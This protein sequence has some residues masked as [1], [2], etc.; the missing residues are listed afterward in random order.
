MKLAVGVCVVV[1]VACLGAASS[2]SS[3]SAVAPTG[4]H[5]FVLRA[6]EP[7]PAGHTYSQMPAFA[8]KPV[9]GAT[10]Y[11]L[12]LATSRS[13]ADSTAIYDDARLQAPV[14]SVPVQVPWMTGR[15]Y[16]LWAH[17]RTWVGNRVSAWSAP[18]G[19]DTAWR[20]VPQQLAAPTGLV[21]WTPVEGA[22][23]Y[24]VWFLD[25]P[26]TSGVRFTTL[27]NVA[28]ERE[29]WTFHAGAAATVHWR[30]R[31]VR[32]VRTAALDN[33]VPI[34][35]YGPYSPV[36][37]STNPT[38]A[39]T[40]PLAGAHV[41]SDV[42]STPGAVRSNALTPG[43][44]WTGA[45]GAGGVATTSGLWR[46]YVFSDRGCVN[47][48]LTGSI[49]GGPAW[50]PR[51]VDPLALPATVDD[52]AQAAAGKALGFGAQDGALMADATPVTASES[53]TVGAAETSTT[54]GAGGASG[55]TGEST[56][57][58]RAV[59]L[60]D[61]GW[62][63]GRYWWTV[64]PVEAVTDPDSGAT[65]PSSA[66]LRYVD[67]E[68]PQDACAA[69]Q[70]W[71]FGVQSAPVTTSSTTPLASGLVAAT[72]VAS[73]ATR[74][75]GFQELP[76][77]TWR[78]APGAAS[79]EVQVSRK[80]YPWK[81]AW[82]RSTDATSAVLPLTKRSVGTWYYRVRGRNP[83]LPAAAAAMAWSKP[84]AIRITGDRFVVGR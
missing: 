58:P 33:G 82:A 38:T 39:P 52:L 70:V 54:A 13:F 40:G 61:N 60:P 79:Y 65:D 50:A 64:V 14:A 5:A 2:W 59:T 12:Q 24:E 80:L 62:P 84:V 4:L 76:L 9:R 45:Q 30:V 10:R 71:P 48:V 44:A 18:F 69:G 7:V 36:F 20:Q 32:T 41:V 28:D 57:G 72:R 55:G 83:D 17:V 53:T 11:E 43:F 67:L 1:V 25:A 31:A 47:R 8:W 78:P 73:A 35:V 51:D 37:T 46:V 74:V 34:T 6:D 81:T 27:T 56:G 16:A 19:F 63:Q 49:V 68:L 29:Y 77:V 75:P 22:T 3:S 26:G 66:A 15:P 21:R 42:D 23:A